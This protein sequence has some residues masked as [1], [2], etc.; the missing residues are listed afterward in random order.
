MECE[1]IPEGG[2]AFVSENLKY[3]DLLPENP[4]YLISIDPASSESKE[5][6]D[7]VIMVLAFW[8]RNI[9]LVEYSAEK[10]EEQQIAANKVLE[11]VRRYNPLGV[12]VESISYQRTL[13]TFIEN[14][15]KVKRIYAP[16]HKV[17]D[18]RRKSDRIIQSLGAAT[19]LGRLY[20]KTSHSKFLTQFARYS[21]KSN[22][23]DDVL[24]ACAI[25]IDA[26]N[27]LNIPDWIEA[28][29]TREDSYQHKQVEFRSCP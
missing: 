11:Y 22:D 2:A 5:A 9:Y 12:Y 25:G 14:E 6:D 20:V 1:I 19:G 13:A 29:Y 27:S 23:H 24:D 3:Y 16:V 7:Q 26:G 28:E 15:M 18:R 8:R 4:T 17:Q 21:P 10:G